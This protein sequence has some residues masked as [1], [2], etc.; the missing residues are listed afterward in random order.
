MVGKGKVSPAAL[1]VKAVQDFEFPRTKRQV[2]QFLGLT[3]YYR[4]FIP[5]Y[6]EHAYNLTEATRKLAPDR[7]KQTEALLSEFS[8]LK[9][10]LCAMPL[11]TLPVPSDSFI[12]QTD[13]SGV[14]LGAVLS[15]QRGEEELPVAFHSR[16]LQPR[17]QKYSAS[18]ME[19]LAVV[20]AVRHFGS[21]LIPQSFVVET[22]HKALTYLMSANH[23]N[24][25]LARWALLLQPYTF[26]I[27]YRPGSQ[28]VNADALS[29][30]FLEDPPSRMPD[31]PAAY[32]DPS[33]ISSTETFGQ[34]EGGG[35][36]V[37]GVS[38]PVAAAP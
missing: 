13:A 14:G 28:H 35:G 15:V 38:L 23:H 30:M 21:Y 25:R 17:E 31:A 33:A 26:T 36:D 34:P 32:E 10:Q 16:K 19:C 3:G 2:R 9:Q 22:D 27:R 6:S 37:M 7:V 12:L 1:K 18:E 20:D 11:L 5:K 8:Y 24:G 4:R 29:R